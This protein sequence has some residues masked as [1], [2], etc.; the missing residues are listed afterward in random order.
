MRVCL[1]I[2][3]TEMVVKRYHNDTLDHG[4]VCE[5]M[6]S[7]SGS[8]SSSS[9]GSYDWDEEFQGVIL[10]SFYWGLVWIFDH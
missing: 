6:N 2:A 3:I 10:S 7:G 5:P 8:G 4:E 9:G 1:N